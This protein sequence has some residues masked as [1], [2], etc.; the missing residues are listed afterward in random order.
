ME[1]NHT[2]N[3]SKGLDLSKE[4][5]YQEDNS[6]TFGLNIINESQEGEIFL[7]QTEPGNILCAELK[8]GYKVIGQC[9]GEDDSMWGRVW[10]DGE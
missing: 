5:L 6:Y 7:K 1:N 2:N 9:N 10:W 3:L 4:A 8:K